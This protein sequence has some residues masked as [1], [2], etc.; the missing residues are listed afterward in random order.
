MKNIRVFGRATLLNC[1]QRQF[2]F[3]FKNVFEKFLLVFAEFSAIK[4]LILN[5]LEISS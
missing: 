2:S 3:S 1:A 4:F 5:E